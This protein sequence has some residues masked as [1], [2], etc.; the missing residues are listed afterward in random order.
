MLVLDLSGSVE[1]LTTYDT[2][3]LLTQTYMYARS[4]NEMKIYP[5]ISPE[6]QQEIT[7][8]IRLNKTTVTTSITQ[9]KTWVTT[10]GGELR[11]TIL[12]WLGVV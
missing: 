7:A 11:T 3:L 1:S 4:S 6:A 9:A 2:L 10:D 12:R 8:P 5:L